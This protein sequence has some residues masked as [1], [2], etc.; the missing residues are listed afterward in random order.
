MCK[1]HGDYKPQDL[2]NRLNSHHFVEFINL[3]MNMNMNM[4]LVEGCSLCKVYRLLEDKNYPPS[5]HLV[6]KRVVILIL[7]G[8]SGELFLSLSLSQVVSISYVGSVL[9]FKGFQEDND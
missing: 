9:H 3:N 8:E 1:V 7:H 5:I 4:N 2:L 6:V